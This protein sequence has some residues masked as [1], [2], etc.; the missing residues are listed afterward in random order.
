[1]P[2]ADPTV[3][4]PTNSSKSDAI[5][6]GTCDRPQF[7]LYLHSPYRVMRNK[8]LVVRG[9]YAGYCRNT[10]KEIQRLR[11]REPVAGTWP[12]LVLFALRS[13]GSQTLRSVGGLTPRG[14]CNSLIMLIVV[15]FVHGFALRELCLHISAHLVLFFGIRVLPHHP[16]R[17][18]EQIVHGFDRAALS[19]IVNRGSPVDKLEL[20][21]VSG[22][23][24]Q[25]KP[26]PV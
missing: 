4:L 18:M 19:S 1:M 21:F 8:E 6:A 24:S 7:V 14:L 9:L 17:H 25:T 2:Y 11:I 10:N 26:A 23:H 22:M 13:Q 20:T 3:A 12:L 15:F 16:Q 5:E